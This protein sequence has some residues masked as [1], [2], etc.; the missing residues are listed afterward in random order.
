MAKKTGEP[1][2]MPF[3]TSHSLGHFHAARPRGFLAYPM[4]GRKTLVKGGLA[5]H[6]G[7]RQ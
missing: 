3:A 7:A 6:S 4:R 1:R 2:K 5:R